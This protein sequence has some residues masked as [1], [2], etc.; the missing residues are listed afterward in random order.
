MMNREQLHPKKEFKSIR[1]IVEYAAVTY[2]NQTAFSYRIKP[3][4]HEKV[5]VSYVEF[6]DDVR[7]LATE[8]LS[9]GMEGKHIVAVGKMSYD[10]AVAYYA[11]LLIGAVFIPLDRDWSATEL[12]NTAKNADIDF[13]FCDADLSDKSEGITRLCE[14]ASPPVYFGA[15]GEDSLCAM[16]AAGRKKFLE[17]RRPYFQVKFDPRKLSLIVYTS[18]TTGKGKGVMHCTDA[19][20]QDMADVIHYVDFG[21]NTVSVLPPHHTYGSTVMLLGHVMIGTEVYFSSGIRYVQKELLTEKPEHIVLVP[22]Y[23]ETFYRKIQAHL[24]NQGKDKLVRSMMKLER[25][26]RKTSF[27]LLDLRE[28]LFSQIKAVFGG[29]VKTIISGGA[30][31]NQEILSFFEGIGIS[32]LNGYGITE[33]AP[34]I[35]VNRSRHV[36]KGSVGTVLEIDDVKIRNPNE[37]GEGEIL[38]KG[39]NVMLGYYKDPDAT[40]EAIDENGYFKTGDYGKLSKDRI[41][42]I[43][44]RKKNLIILSNGKN[45]YPEEIENE[46]IA[47]PGICDVIVYEG[48]S[49]RGIEYNAIVAEI[50]PDQ[51]YMAKNHVENIAAY[52]QPYIREFNRSTL[53]YKKISHVKI[54]KEEFPKNTLRKVL[55]Y[56][57]DTTID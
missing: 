2:G 25:I 34:L 29:E 45:V 46:L 44:G 32:V 47:I 28:K 39:P 19:I 5:T 17:D 48:K 21:K 18:G 42:T 41:L 24:K 22:L 20:I 54:R 23:L 16:I 57:L 3:T 9:R 37:N 31:I 36:V 55:R 40:A 4:D 8:L 11:S 12:A 7:A 26:S 43:T 51:D 50:V 10:F 27:G 1:H 35:S 15:Y 56:K 52:F 14:L 38:V 13:L 33:C 6:R 53:P 49:R 30:P